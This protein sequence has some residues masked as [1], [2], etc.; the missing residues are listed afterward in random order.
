MVFHEV[1]GPLVRVGRG[2]PPAR[3]QCGLAGGEGASYLFMDRGLWCRCCDDE[4]D[5]GCAA[6]PS[7]GAG[8]GLQPDRFGGAAAALHALSTAEA[9]SRAE[10]AAVVAARSGLLASILP[11][12]A[13][14]AALFLVLAYH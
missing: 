6:A 7:L 9:A 10:K 13:L 4:E 12:L 1:K 11:T 3:L 8:G 2:P 14:G 5:E